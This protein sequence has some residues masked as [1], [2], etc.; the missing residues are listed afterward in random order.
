MH[1]CVCVRVCCFFFSNQR[2]I[3]L[4]KNSMFLLSAQS[5]GDLNTNGWYNDVDGMLYPQPTFFDQLASHNVSAK[6]YYQDS[7]WE[8]FMEALA[9]RVD[10]MH[11]LDQFFADAANG[12]LPSFSFINPRLGFNLTSHESQNDNHPDHDLAFGEELIG[13]VFNAL[14]ASPLW[15]NTLLLIT[16][17]EHGGNC[18]SCRCRLTEQK[19]GDVCTLYS[20]AG[21]LLCFSFVI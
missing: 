11:Q 19:S 2:F 16:Y 3:A 18:C 4:A 8:L 13:K 6:F 9:R 21:L 7:P 17:D 20:W 10:Q 14:R 1:V 12:A 5:A 15:N